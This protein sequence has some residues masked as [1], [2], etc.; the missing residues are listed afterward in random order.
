VGTTAT[1][2]PLYSFAH[3]TFLEY[4]AA[5]HL[6][7]E[8]DTPEALARALIPPLVRG[9][10]DIIPELAIAMKD[11]ATSGGGQ[12]VLQAMLKDRRYTS[13]AARRNLLLLAV[14]CLN[15]GGPD[16]GL[17]QDPDQTSSGLPPRSRNRRQG[18]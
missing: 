5:M 4:F 11:E 10:W 1:G 18:A 6:A 7:A 9:E 13:D 2:E 12:R 3:R 17:C 15:L 16:P 14:Y 8:A